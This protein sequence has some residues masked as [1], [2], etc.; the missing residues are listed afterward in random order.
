MNHAK[1]QIIERLGIIMEFYE[2]AEKIVEF[3]PSEFSNLRNTSQLILP[4]LLGV[5]T[6]ATCLFGHK[7]HGVWKAFLFFC[8]GFLLPMMIIEYLF[9]PTGFIFWMCAAL[10]TA[11]GLFCAIHF[12]KIHRAELFIT[13]FLLV[14][15]SVPSYLSFLGDSG[16]VIAGLIIA[17]AAAM[18]SIKY[19]YIT[20]IATTAFSGAFMFFNIIEEKTGLS[21]IPATLLAFVFAL[22]G[23]TVQCYTEKEELKETYSNLKE[24]IKKVKESKNKIDNKIKS[25]KDK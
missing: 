21:H 17:A 5:C 20:V 11:F 6:A 15:I 23:L 7:L 22:I 16:S 24:Q 14:Y 4:W 3:I 8:I 19:K 25:F 2:L 13:T 18:L 1:K 9:M 12:K 10:S